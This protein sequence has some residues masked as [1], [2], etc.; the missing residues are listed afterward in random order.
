[1]RIDPDRLRRL[2]VQRGLSMRELARRSG[3]S[4]GMVSLIEQGKIAGSP[5]TAKKLAE[6]LSNDEAGVTVDD[7]WD[8]GD[9][10]V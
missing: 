7:L 3:V 8:Y 10:D 5:T 2:R 4:V 1:M 6:G 9:S